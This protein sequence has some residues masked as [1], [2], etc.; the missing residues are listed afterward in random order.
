MVNGSRRDFLKVLSTAAMA[1]P[2]RLSAHPPIRP[3]TFDLIIRGATVFDGAGGRGHHLDIGIAGD[4]IVRLGPRLKGRAAEEIDARGLV[5]APGFVDVHSHADG[6]LATDP[7]LES[8]VRQGITTVVVGADGFSRIP[9]DKGRAAMSDWFAEV[10]ALSPG[11]NVASMVGLGRVRELVV[12]EDDRPATPAELARMVAMVKAAL[13]SGACGASAGLEYTPGAFAGVDELVAL[14]RPLARYRLPYS[15]HMRNEDDRLVEAVEESLEVGRRARC[16]VHIAHLKTQGP[17]NWSKLDLVFKRMA[18]ARRAGHDVTFDRYPYLAYQTGVSNLFPLWSRD[19]GDEAFLKRLADSSLTARLSEAVEAKV[20]LIGGWDRVMVS[21]VSAEADR[22][23]EGKRIS[24]LGADHYQ[25]AVGLLQRNAAD[26]GMV[27]FAMSEDNLERI[28]KHPHAMVASDGGAVALDGP[29]RGHPHPRSLGT[30]PRV[31][32][33]YVRERK[34]LSLGAA[35]RK[36]SSAPAG[37]VRLDR[38]GRIA[39]GWFADLVIFDPATVADR[40]TFADPFAYPEGI[41]V[42]VVNGAV[43]L[44]D[45]Q[46]GPGTGRPLRPGGSR[47]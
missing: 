13:R 4:R 36:M 6:S 43:A 2:I 12:G 14:C 46:R 40:A 42:V 21:S 34:V 45:G 33:H 26:V 10:D 41:S 5:V 30:F 3:S 32:G 37:R 16:P 25:L 11:A 24:E 35:I 22:G 27:G 18:R 38:R 8:V 1:G 23:A 31:L 17:R 9:D 7:R 15:P 47:A 20:A 28:L 39:L 29:R 44:R 19:G